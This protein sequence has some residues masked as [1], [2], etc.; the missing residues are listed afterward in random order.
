MDTF[1]EWKDWLVR[2]NN[3]NPME[4]WENQPT[5]LMA[6]L[7]YI[8]M[9]ILALKSAVRNGGWKSRYISFSMEWTGG[10]N[11]NL[12]ATLCDSNVTFVTFFLKKSVFCH[13]ICCL[14]ARNQLAVPGG[15]KSFLRG[16]QI[17]WTMSNILKLPNTFFQRGRKIEAPPALPWMVTGLAVCCLCYEEFQ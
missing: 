15:A 14:Q 6:N 13:E 8:T 1:R 10:K 2:V 4:M 16:A 3:P 12:K 7:L 17:F 5:Y 9:A 11:V